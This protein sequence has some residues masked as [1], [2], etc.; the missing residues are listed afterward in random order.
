[1]NSFKVTANK[2]IGGKSEIERY[3]D[4]ILTR[5]VI[6]DK[7][8]DNEGKVI[9]VRQGK[10]F[11]NNRLLRNSDGSFL[12]MI[13]GKAQNKAFEVSR[14]FSDRS[15]EGIN[16]RKARPE[17][18]NKQKPVSVVLIK[19]PNNKVIEKGESVMISSEYSPTPAQM[20][21]AFRNQ[22]GKEIKSCLSTDFFTIKKV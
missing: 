12:R 4:G 16:P 20:E 5:I 15:W 7:K 10:R 11:E 22:C 14:T 1:M 18:L 9:N 6:K 8:I 2:N 3:E 13:D 17:E 21:E 19:I